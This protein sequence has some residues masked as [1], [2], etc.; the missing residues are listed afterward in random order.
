MNDYQKAKEYDMLA[1]YYKYANADLHI[2]YYKKHLHHLQTALKVQRNN[3]ELP[4]RVRI[5]HAAPDYALVD[6]YI[7]GIK[8]FKELN[9]Q[10]VS[11]YMNL[12]AGKYQID[13]Y[14]TG[15]MNPALFSRK[16]EVLAGQPFTL[17][18]AGHQESRRLIILRENHE[19][20]TGEVK[21]NFV[22]LAPHLP[23]VDVAV[24]DGD[25]VFSAVSY[26]QYTNYL[27]L[28]PMSVELEL[29]EIGSNES[30][31]ILPPLEFKPNGNYSI[32]LLRAKNSEMECRFL[33]I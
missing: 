12:P 11:N 4:G 22:H 5:L 28:S 24:K 17:A 1:Q 9:Y 21:I 31:A 15:Q 10:N 32:V 29:R 2:K 19:V 3:H 33:I 30:L 7:N 6:V 26:K 27:G 18:P 25:I 14:P 13:I 23:E 16:I 20:P 8:I